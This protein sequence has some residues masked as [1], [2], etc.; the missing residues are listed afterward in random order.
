M[1]SRA[2]KRTPRVIPCLTLEE[3]PVEMESRGWWWGPHDAGDFHPSWCCWQAARGIPTK[4]R[5]VAAG[6]RNPEGI[7][8]WSTIL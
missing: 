3:S 1:I 8:H 4:A 6:D 5:R 7:R 2:A